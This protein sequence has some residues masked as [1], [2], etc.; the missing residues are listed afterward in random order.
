MYFFY[1]YLLELKDKVIN[2]MYNKMIDIVW[3]L[4]IYYDKI[5]NYIIKIY[6]KSLPNRICDEN[7][8]W[9]SV[10]YIK[11]DD[12]KPYLIEKYYKT[13]EDVK[14]FI[15]NNPFLIKK[16]LFIHN[17]NKDNC[18]VRKGEITN[19]N[20]IKDKPLKTIVY[21]EYRHP[22]MDEP[23]IFNNLSRYC[24]KDNDLFNKEFILRCLE[25]NCVNGDYVFD[26]NFSLTIMDSEFNIL[27]NEIRI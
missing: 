11:Y 25:Y 10:C 9:Y 12:N 18:V 5:N 21:A 8:E 26:D 4:C 20:V 17:I 13:Y 6:P 27:E 14:I 7:T 3:N 19:N 24:L 1:N 16:I 22:E 23:F 15:N 2:V